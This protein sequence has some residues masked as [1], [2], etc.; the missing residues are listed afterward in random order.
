MVNIYTIIIR[1]VPR[2]ID[3]NDLVSQFLGRFGQIKDIRFGSGRGVSGDVMFVDYFSADAAHRAVEE[4]HGKKDPGVSLAKLHVSI[5]P[6]SLEAMKREEC[7][8]SKQTVTINPVRDEVPD[9]VPN[10]PRRLDD[11][12]L[13]YLRPK[14]GGA[15][16]CVI[17]FQALG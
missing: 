2:G 13:Q 5:A 6:T 11:A 8:S 1:P 16:I 4:M 14:D 7:E 3:R 9:N 17:D 15:E 10:F 12:R